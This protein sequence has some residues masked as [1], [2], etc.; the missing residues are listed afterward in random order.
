MI[1]ENLK[2]LDEINAGIAENMTYNEFKNIYPDEYE[3]RKN[4][5][6]TYKYPNDGESYIDLILRTKQFCDKIIEKKEDVLIISH[7]AITRALIYHFCKIDILKV[8]EIEIPLHKILVIKNLKYE[9]IT[10]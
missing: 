8:P 4:N 1:I 5:K 6:L 2:C 9:I 10:P 7:Q 3:K